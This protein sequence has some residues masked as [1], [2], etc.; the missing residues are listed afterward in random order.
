M[1]QSESHKN[2]TKSKQSRKFFVSPVKFT[3]VHVQGFVNEPTIM[4]TSKKINYL[5]RVWPVRHAFSEDTLSTRSCL[6]GQ[7]NPYPTSLD[8]SLPLPLKVSSTP[9]RDI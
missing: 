5:E 1:L 2:I 6:E 3:N 9:D 4:E 8:H 7:L